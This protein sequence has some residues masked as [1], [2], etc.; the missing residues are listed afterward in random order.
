M[1]D[2]FEDF[3]PL[4]FLDFSKELLEKCDS[5]NVNETTIKRVAYGRTYYATFLF[6]REWLKNHW[7]Y[8][9]S[10]GDHTQM[11]KFIRRHGRFGRIMNH[12][13]ADDLYHLKSLRHQADYYIT[14][15]SEDE[16]GENDE[17][18]CEDIEIAFELAESIIGA[19]EDYRLNN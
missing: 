19:F 1:F 17:W 7:S 18:Y 11:L 14:I 16:L 9:S 10:K 8:R 2:N 13:I 5:F 6:V 3:D 4:Y 12:K 15:P